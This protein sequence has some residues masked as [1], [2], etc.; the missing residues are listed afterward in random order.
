MGES[1]KISHTEEFQIVYVDTAPSNRWNIL[2]LKHR[3]CIVTSKE[4]KMK[5]G[6]E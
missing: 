4:Y 2:P 6:K 3:L 5:T 1:R